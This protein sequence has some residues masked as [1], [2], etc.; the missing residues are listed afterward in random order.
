MTDITCRHDYDNPLRKGRAHY[1][2]PK[3]GVDITLDLVYILEAEQRM[4][5]EQQTSGGEG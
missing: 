4:K 5:E 1:V 3:C 2:F